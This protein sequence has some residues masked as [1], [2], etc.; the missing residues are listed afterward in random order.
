MRQSGILAAAGI[1]ALENNIDRLAKDHHNARL[2]AERVS[3][4]EGIEI[5]LETVQTNIVVMN[6]A[7]L[8]VDPPQVM[9]LLKKRGLLV[10]VFGPTKL[11]AVAHLDVSE[12]DIFAAARIFEETFAELKT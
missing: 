8:R 7:G 5:D 2:F 1:Y 12:S 9:E 4:I 10:V 11:R 6:I 3:K